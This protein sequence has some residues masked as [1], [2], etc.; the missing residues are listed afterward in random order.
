MIWY[1]IEPI[2]SENLPAALKLAST[3][4]I[5]EL[6]RFI[7]RRIVDEDAAH[8]EQV[9]ASVLECRDK[10]VRIDLLQGVLAALEVS[11]SHDP[12]D[13]WSDLY[14]RNAAATGAEL[15]S[16]LVR[17]ATL[18]GDKPAIA[19]LR[20]VVLDKSATA[21]ERRESFLALLNVKDGVEVSM[22]HRLVKEA[23][24]LR[25][26]ALQSLVLRH[27]P[28]TAGV[29][30]G[31]YSDLNFAERQDAISVLGTRR[32]FASQLLG[33]I[34]RGVIER[35]D[36]SAFALQQLRAYRD[37]SIQQQVAVL[38]ADDAERLSKADEIARY[39]AQM[40]PAYLAQ[41]NVRAGRALFE[42]TCS[43]C[44]TLFGEGGTIAPDLTGSG[45]KQ[46]DYVL[47]NLIDPSAVIDPA[48]RLTTM[49]TVD[50]RVLSGFIVHQGDKFLVLRTQEA[51]VRLAMGDI[52]ELHTSS[53]SMMPEGMLRG[54]SDEE[55]R[56][57]IVYL[58]S[59]QQVSL[60]ESDEAE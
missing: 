32:A 18:F 16:T 33:A 41:G 21:K 8:A 2:V 14:T 5:P 17:L 46:L 22:L 52:D 13:S 58:A 9:F 34:E 4:R 51:Q 25:R 37:K 42:R 54:L 53:K 38:W 56:D 19:R 40:T 15:R 45:R 60:G 29:I 12:P 30:L 44:H 36:V 50:G 28:S 1:G 59:P 11:G 3:T 23:S 55:F 47:S 26:E 43:K 31:V 10:T 27:E 24:I 35:N 57:L 39:K 20:R 48:Y 7:A 6:R 49:I